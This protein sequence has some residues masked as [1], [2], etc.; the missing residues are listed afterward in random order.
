MGEINRLRGDLP[1]MPPTAC[2]IV[3]SAKIEQPEEP[4]PPE[5]YREFFSAMEILPDT[6]EEVN[7]VI[8]NRRIPQEGAMVSLTGMFYQLPLIND[9]DVNYWSRNH[10][11]LLVNSAIRQTYVTSGNKAMLDVFSDA[12][13]KDIVAF[14]LDRVEEAIFGRGQ[15][16]SNF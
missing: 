10:H 1:T 11:M 15:M 14:G 16:R 13:E 2:A 7:A 6:Q 9:E 4:I 12:I 3:A 8:F 5:L